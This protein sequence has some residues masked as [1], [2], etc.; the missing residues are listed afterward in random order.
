M[1]RAIAN[2]VLILSALFLL[3]AQLP[4]QPTIGPNGLSFL[5]GMIA[6]GVTS[7]IVDLKIG[8][9]G[10]T[11]AKGDTVQYLDGIMTAGGNTITSASAN[12]KK[13]DIGKQVMM[14]GSGTLSSFTGAPQ[15]GT[16]TACVGNAFQTSF[17]AVLATPWYGAWSGA[18]KA[19]PGGTAGTPQSGAGSYAPNDTIT[20]SGGT[21]IVTSPVFTIATTQVVSATVAA[22]GN[23]C[24]NGT[25]QTVTGTTGTGTKFQ[26]LV[27]V[28]G[29]AITAVNS[30]SV[31]GSYT[32]NPTSLTNEPV[33][34]D[35]CVG[36]QLSVKMGYLTL[37]LTNPG[38]VGQFSTN[39]EATTT[40]GSGTGATVNIGVYQV[41]GQFLYG[42]DDT[43]AVT[44]M[45]AY[46]STLG[47]ALHVPHGGYWLESQTTSIP[48]NNIMLIGD[49]IPSNAYPFINTGATFLISNTATSVF[50][51]MSSV[52]I[53]YVGFYWPLQDNS[54]ATSVVY[55]PLFESSQFVNN[56]FSHMR[57][58]NAYQLLTVDAN[59]AIGSGLGRVTFDND[60]I[61]CIDR[62]FT[63][64][65]GAADVLK[66]G[67]TNIWSVGAFGNSGTGGP[68][69]LYKHSV[70]SGEFIHID[71]GSATYTK[72]DGLQLNND[73]IF[74]MRYGIRLLSGT[75]DVSN[76]T[77]V[78]WDQVPT[79]LSV[80]GSTGC[81]V[82]TSFTGGGAYA[83]D[84][85]GPANV[86]NVFNFPGTN[87]N[88]TD[89]SF[90][91]GMHI[92]Y[93]MGSVFFEG[94]N[95]F[96]RLSITGMGSIQNW[97]QSTTVNTY[98]GIGIAADQNVDLT[99]AGNH[100]GCLNAGSN[101]S[102]GISITGGS[103]SQ[104]AI[105]GNAFAGCTTAIV[106]GGTNG[107]YRL[108]SNISQGTGGGKSVNDTTSAS[109]T[110]WNDNNTW[111]KP[112][113]PA[114]A[115]GAGDC[116]TSPSFA[117][118]S[119]DYVGRLTVGSGANGGLCTVT[120]NS[121]TD[122]NPVCSVL[123]ETT[124]ANQI[125]SIASSNKVVAFTALVAITAGDV[126]TYQCRR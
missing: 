53:Q 48:L 3:T 62:C 46:A 52:A 22:G 58:L 29:N 39:P 70:A 117:A 41:A 55:P 120:F 72:F 121:A 36:S 101:A 63:L 43:A 97:G 47:A 56:S 80:E 93:A 69:N 20:I 102:T 19:P 98:Y 77:G 123:D 124:K 28:S 118:K 85:F 106:L 83:F 94:G 67:G 104:T 103:G 90:G 68:A 9:P 50:S 31:A 81:I 15:Q 92:D 119:D 10:V 84:I 35:S 14:H 12:C 78:Y 21:G 107:V 32:V 64:L 6:N 96:K 33:T 30:I 17:S 108:S 4:Y 112:Q 65:N 82:S 38:Q 79:V 49:D 126:L 1:R 44:A 45:I 61:Y 91:G 5:G 25:S 57:V 75:I 95:Q 100:F 42:T 2:T 18:L 74:G 8:A 115:N 26:A 23:T 40:S 105:T 99:V 113:A 16:I 87:A 54:Q 71:I 110:V 51:G 111:D 59:V 88:C 89:I 34:G 66:T 76:I 27:T 60:L 86:Q 116:G 37:T 7:G 13:A 24:V 109:A 125:D 11:G 114:V 122:K 73:F